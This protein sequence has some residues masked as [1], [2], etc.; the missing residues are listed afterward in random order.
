MTGALHCPNLPGELQAVDKNLPANNGPVLA[1]D[2][3]SRSRRT[4]S[5]EVSR[6]RKLVLALSA[7]GLSYQRSSPLRQQRE[8]KLSTFQHYRRRAFLSDGF[9]F[10]A[11]SSQHQ[12]RNRQKHFGH[13]RQVGVV[14]AEMSEVPSL[15]LKRRA[16][17][18]ERK[19][20]QKQQQTRREIR[21]KV[22]PQR[23]QLRQGEHAGK[24]LGW[25][26]KRP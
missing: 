7:A 1:P 10:D 24:S 23:L 5:S 18:I 16:T 4:P 6:I 19:T 25:A 26:A 21:F 20:L 3:R 2:H 15:L 22:I 11:F 17:S 14:I 12:Q 8:L 13:T 9:D